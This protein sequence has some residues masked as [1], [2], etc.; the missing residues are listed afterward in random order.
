[1]NPSHGSKEQVIEK[2][3]AALGSPGIKAL[4]RKEIIALGKY[5][6]FPPLLDSGI[7]SFKRVQ[8]MEQC[9]TLFHI[10]E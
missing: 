9:I 8:K 6:R 1:V 2:N 5:L 7:L 3:I 4:D 10:S